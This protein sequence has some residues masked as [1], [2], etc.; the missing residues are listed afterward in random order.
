MLTQIDASG[1]Q[2]HMFCVTGGFQRDY[3]GNYK[4]WQ[5]DQLCYT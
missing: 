1:E 2:P 3:K 5:L 4:G